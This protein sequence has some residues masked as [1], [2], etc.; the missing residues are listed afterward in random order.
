MV[1]KFSDTIHTM[2]G[3]N[4]I[5]AVATIRYG[6]AVANL[7]R[8]EGSNNNTPT[9]DRARKAM[10]YLVYI[11]SASTIPVAIQSLRRPRVNAV[12]NI[13]A[14]NAHQGRFSVLLLKRTARQF[15]K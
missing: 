12:W 1:G 4:K 11:P 13:S 6:P 8:A 3:T 10:S 9:T 5:K 14:V 15:K 7:G 2:C